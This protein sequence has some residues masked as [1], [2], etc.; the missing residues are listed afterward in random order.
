[1]RI[2]FSAVVAAVL[3]VPHAAHAQVPSPGDL[4]VVCGDIQ[5]GNISYQWGQYGTWLEYIVSTN[6]PVSTCP[7]TVWV[8]AYVV[9]VSQS[10]YSDSGL[11][12][13]N[14]RR[15]IPMPYPGIWQTNGTHTVTWWITSVPPVGVSFG[16]TP[17]TSHAAVE[18]RQ[19]RDPEAECYALGGEWDGWDCYIP[20]CPLVVDT[21]HDGFKLTSPA[22]GVLF[23]LD[24]DGVAERIAW[25]EADSDEAFLVMDRNGN[26]RVDDGSELFGNHTP[27]LPGARSTAGNGF[28]ALKFTE[29]PAFGESAIDGVLERGDAVFSRLLLWRDANHNGVS[30]PE[31]LTPVDG[32]GLT[33][34]ATDY[35]T[36]RKKDRHGNEFRQRAKASWVDGDYFIYDVWLRRQ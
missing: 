2:V 25:T 8:A 29:G 28:E 10:G 20:N 21:K 7:L 14:A 18:W 27:V 33:A 36:S 12:S 15:Q 6:R 34:I 4:K 9:G 17:T 13:A 32:S 16:L 26:G 30:E 31:E 11:F 24:A 5:R 23:D 1:M 19:R 3:L 35:K 22:D